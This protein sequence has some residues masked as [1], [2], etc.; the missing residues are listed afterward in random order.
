[1]KN[2]DKETNSDI[3]MQSYNE[4]I[5]HDVKTQIFI[6]YSALQLMELYGE[7]DSNES[8]SHRTLARGIKRIVKLVS[9]SADARKIMSEA[10]AVRWREYNVLEIIKDIAT[11]AEAIANPKGITISIES[12]VEEKCIYIDKAVLERILLNLLSN[13]VK[14]TELE[15][16]I[17]VIL[18]DKGDSIVI[19][20]EDNGMGIDEDKLELIFERYKV[21]NANSGSGIGLAIVREL[22]GLLEG[23]AY[24]KNNVGKKGSS[25]VI[26][27]PVLEREECQ[28]DI[29][30][31][32]YDTFNKEISIQVELSDEY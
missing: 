17:V 24:A 13:A 3:I 18:E 1:M 6:A 11:E 31:S 26:D 16:E 30:L 28:K 27:L 20:V 10:Y 4:D 2:S 19:T 9:D 5:L 7:F 23:T 29:E 12:N 32:W 22:V 15:G 21:F 14:Y 25:I 8:K